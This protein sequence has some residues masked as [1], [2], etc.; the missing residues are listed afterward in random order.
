MKRLCIIVLLSALAF[1]CSSDNEEARQL[2]LGSWKYDTQAI[3]D[4]LAQLNIG[5]QEKQSIKGTLMIYKDA[6]FTFGA[7]ST[8]V[9]ASSVIKQYGSWKMSKN[10]KTLFL[11]LSGQ[12][13]PNQVSELGPN[14]LVLAP[15]PSKGLSYTRIF[16]RANGGSA[17]Q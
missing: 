4:Q 7:D 8:L 16:I 5:E 1:A 2:I 14:R 6:L 3:L 9:V 17:G 12:D 13:Q 15:D 10:G 11:N